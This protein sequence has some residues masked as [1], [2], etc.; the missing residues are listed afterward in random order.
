[1]KKKFKPEWKQFKVGKLST[2]KYWSEPSCQ[3]LTKVSHVSHIHSALSIISEG[4]LKSGLIFDESKLNEERILVNWVSPNDWDGAGGFRYGHIRFTFDWQKLIAG[5]NYYWVESIAYGI[6]AC[7]ILITDKDYSDALHLYDPTLRDGP[8]W[9][10]ESNDKHYWNGNYCLE[11]MVERD[12]NLSEV[13]KLDFVRHHPDFCCLPY[14][15]GEQK[16][17]RPKAVSIFIAGIVHRYIEYDGPKLYRMKKD[18]LRLE[19]SFIDGV[20]Y[21]WRYIEGLDDFIGNVNSKDEA[22]L[23]LARAVLSAYANS[24]HNEAEELATFFN[25]QK[26]LKYSCAKLIAKTFDIP[27][28]KILFD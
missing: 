28:W 10:D 16:F 5:M 3:S 14:S 6:E 2:Q 1:M 22:A 27:D 21:I 11:I 26:S 18:K 15:C 25:S 13:V 23:P 24:N 20:D 4:K 12:L 17:R 9:Y 7:R 8:W 19:W